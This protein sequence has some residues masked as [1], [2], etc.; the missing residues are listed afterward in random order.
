M[1]QMKFF[2][3]SSITYRTGSISTKSNT[4]V[5]QTSLY[6]KAF[7]ANPVILAIELTYFNAAL[8]DNTVK[9]SWQT[10][11][12]YN[13]V[14]FAVERSADGINFKPLSVISGAGVSTTTLDYAYTDNNPMVGNNYYRLRQTVKGDSVSYS[15][16]QVVNMVNGKSAGNDLVIEEGPNPFNNELKINC[17]YR[18]DGKIKCELLNSSG[19]TIKSQQKE[20]ENGNC[21]FYFPDL[22]DVPSGTYFVTVTAVNKVKSVKVVKR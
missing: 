6:F 13:S 20:S 14:D 2:N 3:V 15:N 7:F 19:T 1:F 4:D 22:S 16:V 11:S 10:S 8:N 18:V 5:R 21:E 12:E 9:L 17:L